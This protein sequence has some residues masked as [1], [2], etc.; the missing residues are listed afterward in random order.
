MKGHSEETKTKAIE[1]RLSDRSEWTL[2]AIGQ[3]LG[4]SPRSI[5]AWFRKAEKDNPKWRGKLLTGCQ[6]RRYDRAKILRELNATKPNGQ[7]KYTRKQIAEKHGCSAK[8]LS[9]LATGRI[10]P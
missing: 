5:R 2:T 4:V 3:K 8:F 10:Q 7:P 1:L 6:E 9:D